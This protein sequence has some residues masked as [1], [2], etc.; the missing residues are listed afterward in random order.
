MWMIVLRK[1][2][3]QICGYPNFAPWYDWL[4]VEGSSRDIR[5]C[6]PCFLQSN[7]VFFQYTHSVDWWLPPSRCLTISC[8]DH[9]T[10]RWAYNLLSASSFYWIWK[11]CSS[12]ILACAAIVKWF[13]LLLFFAKE[14]NVI[15]FYCGMEIPTVDVLS[16]RCCVVVPF[17]WVWALCW[18][19]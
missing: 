13:I 11:V 4:L 3:N 19:L 5:H 6:V 9:H 2:G 18:T 16:V 10:L 12:S 8:S 14:I 17:D 15:W 7:F 1:S